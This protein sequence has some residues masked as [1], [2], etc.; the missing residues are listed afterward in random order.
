[1]LLIVFDFIG[2]KSSYKTSY[3][4]SL[5]QNKCVILQTENQRKY[6]P[7]IPKI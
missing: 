3:K 7:N 6:D 1:M 2:S 5:Y 4:T